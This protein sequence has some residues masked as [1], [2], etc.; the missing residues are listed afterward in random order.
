MSLTN[1]TNRSRVY[2]TRQLPQKGLDLLLG[3]CNVSYWDSADPAPRTELLR[4]IPGID[5]LVCMP[6]DKID[7]EIL[8]AA[9]MSFSVVV[10]FYRFKNLY[11]LVYFSLILIALN[12]IYVASSCLY[13]GNGN[14]K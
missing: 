13:F 4:N 7:R 1:T 2:V 11:L 8:N 5:V 3:R 14:L 6:T 12:I 10:F 9:G